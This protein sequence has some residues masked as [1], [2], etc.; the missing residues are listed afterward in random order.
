MR[1]ELICFVPR[2][3]ISIIYECIIVGSLSASVH[4]ALC[5]NRDKLKDLIFSNYSVLSID[6]YFSLSKGHEFCFSRMNLYRF[7]FSA[8]H[9]ARSIAMYFSQHFGFPNFLLVLESPDFK[10]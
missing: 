7:L 6:F 2:R 5:K 9:L 10:I 1:A 3:T 4:R 8:R